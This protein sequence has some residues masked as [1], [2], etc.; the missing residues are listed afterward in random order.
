M[1]LCW[2][3]QVSVSDGHSLELDAR[4]RAWRR[5]FF[6][7]FP[8]TLY[9]GTNPS[10]HHTIF[11][12]VFHKLSHLQLFSASL[13]S[14][15]V[16]LS[17]CISARIVSASCALSSLLLYNVFLVLLIL[18]QFCC[19][20]LC[21]YNTFSV[22]SCR[23]SSQTPKVFF[24]SKLFSRPCLSS[25]EQTEEDAWHYRGQFLLILHD[26]FNIPILLFARLIL[27]FFL[28]AAIIWRRYQ[29]SKIDIFC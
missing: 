6:F 2:V 17:S 20:W 4:V 10:C 8:L 22:F 16:R 14:F 21:L 27:R 19:C 15:V 24:W 7:I 11:L 29:T 3:R 5:W 28:G 13:L 26:V 12:L 9:S 1:I 25:T 23:I 18:S